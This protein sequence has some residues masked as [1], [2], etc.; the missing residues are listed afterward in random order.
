MRK[1]NLK[2]MG[3][4]RENGRIGVRNHVVIIPVDDLSNAAAEGVAHLVRG[5]MAIPHPYGRL[6]FG[7]DLELTF[8]TLIGTGRNPNVAAAIV[9]GIE[10]NWTERIVQGIAETGKPVEGFSIER[11]G[12]LKTVEAAAR[13]AVQF[14]QWASELKREPFE[15][16]ELVVSAKCGESDTT[17]GLASNPAV[18]RVLER[19]VDAG[20][21]AIFGETSEIT[22]AEDI[23][24]SQAAT[25]EVAEK[26]MRAFR[27]YQEFIK[28]Q[29]VDLLGSQPTQGNI[30]GGLSTIE[31]KALGNIQKI[32]RNKV[33]SVLAPAEEPKGP[34][35]HFMDSSSAAAEMVTLCAAAGSV[36]H[37]FATGQGNVVG[38]PI[39]PV[40]KLCANPVTV[41]T[42]SEHI[43][44]DLSDMLKLKLSL[45]E[46]ADK[47]M[48]VLVRTVN[49]RLT[50]A[51]VLRH[52][53]FVL[54]KLYRSA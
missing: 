15:L 37:F 2:L 35:L 7:E 30:R 8:R 9:I 47:L 48:E 3:Y 41:R 33:Q 46:A 11:S 13:R 36:V 1:E 4:R 12:D 44:V 26:F 24:A 16:G 54:T 52:D 31:E 27:S 28:S 45:D 51:E 21:T 10:P 19:L 50:A 20:A 40:I 22:G 42:M 38:N 17:L 29:G 32:G 34:G 53:E 18:G 39:V 14:V 43:D 6:Q 23:V 25:P 49:G 5:T